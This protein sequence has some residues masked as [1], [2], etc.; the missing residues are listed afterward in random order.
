MR[1]DG[2]EW[3]VECAEPPSAMLGGFSMWRGGVVWVLA[4]ENSAEKLK[5]SGRKYL[6]FVW[7]LWY[8][9]GMKRIKYTLGIISL[10]LGGV[11]LTQGV[12]AE[13]PKGLSYQDSVKLQFDWDSSLSMTIDDLNLIVND[14]VP[15]GS[16]GVSNTINIGVTTNSGSGYTLSATV[17][18][19]SNATTDLTLAGV[20]TKF[21]MLGTSASVSS[22]TSDDTWGYSINGGNYSG[23]PVYTATAK[24][25]CATGGT[26]ACGT[27]TNNTSTNTFKISAK[28]GGT[29]ARGDYTNVINFAVVAN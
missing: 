29:M 20:S 18:N 22:I 12:W 24:T 1:S 26:P 4:V 13:T 9:R 25:I 28:A 5:I 14:L 15:G 19:A 6:C 21:G 11:I 16:A 10:I 7:W 8:N 23:L 3:I 17:G 27:I 2:S